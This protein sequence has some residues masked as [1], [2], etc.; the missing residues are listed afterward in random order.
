MKNAAGNTKQKFFY[1]WKNVIVRF[2]L[3]VS[4]NRSARRRENVEGGKKEVQILISHL[5]CSWNIDQEV[6]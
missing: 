3:F 2:P 4:I 1:N 6:F 5:H